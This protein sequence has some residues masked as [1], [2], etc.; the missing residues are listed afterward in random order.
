MNPLQEKGVV[1]LGGGLHVQSR[2]MHVQ[3]KQSLSSKTWLPSSENDELR[4]FNVSMTPMCYGLALFYDKPS[5]FANLK[6]TEQCFSAKVFSQWGIA[7]LNALYCAHTHYLPALKLHPR[8]FM[9]FTNATT[10][11]NINTFVET[12]WQCVMIQIIM[13]VWIDLTSIAFL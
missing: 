1:V 7:A 4:L 10:L 5:S 3:G 8:G 13:I 6:H 9:L 11:S 2:A 12:E